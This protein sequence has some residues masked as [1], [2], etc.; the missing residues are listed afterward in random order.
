VRFDLDVIGDEAGAPV[1]RKL[2]SHTAGGLV[3][4]IIRI[5]ESEDCARVPQDAA[6]HR[7][8][9][10]VQDCVL[11]ACAWL[12][13]ATTSGADEA[14]NGMVE[15]E[16]RH[17]LGVEARRATF[18]RIAGNEPPPAFQHTWNGTASNH[19]PHRRR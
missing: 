15:S 2:Q 8:S 12:P 5:E 11:V 19:A 18:Q 13:A 17:V 10:A 16:R 14:E 6:S 9:A 3:I 4:S 1:R 7:C